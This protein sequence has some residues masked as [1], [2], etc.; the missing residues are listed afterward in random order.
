[1][2]TEREK[3]LL[4]SWIVNEESRLEDDVSELRSRVRYRRIDVSDCFELALALERLDD[5]REFAL[6]VLRLLH[7]P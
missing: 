7:L 2:M 3:E 6:I 1:M 4:L 5:F